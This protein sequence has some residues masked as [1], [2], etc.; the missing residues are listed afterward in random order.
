MAWDRELTGV[1]GYGSFPVTLLPDND[2]D[3][4]DADEFFVLMQ[5]VYNR[6]EFLKAASDT[7]VTHITNLET[8]TGLDKTVTTEPTYSSGN[9][10]TTAQS[11]KE[12]VETL[13]TGILGNTT[14][15]TNINTNVGGSVSGSGPL[16]YATNNVISNGQ[17]HHQAIEAFD[18]QVN[19]NNI[20]ATNA[21]SVASTNSSNITNIANKVGDNAT[22]PGA[23]F[24]YSSQVYLSA[25]DK[26]DTAVGKLDAPVGA[27]RRILERIFEQT[28]L[29]WRDTSFG[30]G[31]GATPNNYLFETLENT[32]KLDLGNSSAVIDLPRRQ[33][34]SANAAWTYVSNIVPIPG[35]TNEIKMK[36]QVTG[37]VTI[38]V[39]F[40][41]SL[42]SGFV[43]IPSEDTYVS[44][45]TG[46]QLIIKI[47]GSAGSFLYN[48]AA[49]YRG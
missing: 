2:T 48:Y 26:L 7:S 3:D 23:G 1:A 4:V 16:T 6:L 45:P 47:E 46:T 9:L 12:A 5:D 30:E 19:T 10:L 25:G 34:G 20:N 32:T 18:V 33:F 15:A 35:T 44:V 29:N 41:G 22:L 38:S 28:V 21:A 27:D 17:T 39:N 8:G 43:T 37:T 24:T 11:L 49:L 42:V 13:D 31:G 36:F 40:Q 14:L